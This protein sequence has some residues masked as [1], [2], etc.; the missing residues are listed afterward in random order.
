M[1]TGRIKGAQNVNRQDQRSPKC[2]QAGL[3]EPKMSTGGI[4]G[5]QNVNRQD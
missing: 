3:K 4:K 5:A 2:Q 1:S